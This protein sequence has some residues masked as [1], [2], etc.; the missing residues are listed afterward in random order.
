MCAILRF[1]SGPP[2]QSPPYAWNNPGKGGD[3]LPRGRGLVES[4][5][6]PPPHIPR[7]PSLPF[8]P[9]FK[10]VNKRTR[11]YGL[12]ART[13]YWPVLPTYLNELVHV[14]NSVKCAA[15]IAAASNRQGIG[16]KETQCGAKEI[17]ESAS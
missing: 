10:W 8:L 16:R 6:L 1:A 7:F 11:A 12:K 9:R 13:T 17:L 15:A 5:G 14:L 4:G 3:F 2:S